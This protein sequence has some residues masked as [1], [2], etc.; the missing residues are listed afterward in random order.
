VL[1]HLRH[2]ILIFSWG[3]HIAARGFAWG[4][5]YWL[6]GHVLVADHLEEVVDTVEPGTPLVICI[7]GVPMRVL[8]VGMEVSA[9]SDGETNIR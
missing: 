1:K 7:Y 8:L 6:R 4:Q 9:G 5:F 3:P 2:D